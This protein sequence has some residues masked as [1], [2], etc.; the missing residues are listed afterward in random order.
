MLRHREKRRLKGIQFQPGD[1]AIDI[2]AND[3]GT[4]ALLRERGAIVHA[5]EPQPTVFD[6]LQQRFAG[7][8]GVIC[9][10]AAAWTQG[11]SIKLYCHESLTEAASV[12]K[13]KRNVDANLCLEVPTIDLAQFVRDHAP[14]KLLYINAEGAEYELVRH[15]CKTGAVEHVEHVIAST[16]R[17]KIAGIEN[18]VAAAKAVAEQHGIQL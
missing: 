14:I 1:V 6:Q 10:K 9:Y 16:H 7:D 13:G 18:I 12:Y 8:P 17:K 5:F 4:T 3:G 15:L 2:G 11:G